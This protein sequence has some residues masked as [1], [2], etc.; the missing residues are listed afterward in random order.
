MNEI[1]KVF[2]EFGCVI[3]LYIKWCYH[4]SWGKGK[5]TKKICCYT[6]PVVVSAGVHHSDPVHTF[7]D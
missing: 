1:C 4:K 2:I 3:A 6:D 7:L 5:K